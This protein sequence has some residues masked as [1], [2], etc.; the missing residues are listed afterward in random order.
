M[1]DPMPP[2]RSSSRATTIAFS[3]V[4]LGLLALLLYYVGVRQVIGLLVSLGWTAP[5]IMLPY[6]ILVI[7]DVIGWRRVLSG[8]AGRAL[9][10]WRLYVIRLAGEAVNSI[11]P[12]AGLAGEPVKAYLL[13]QHGIEASAGVA[14]VVIAKGALITAQI[15]FTLC[16]LALLLDLL[17]V[18][19]DQVLVLIGAWI[20]GIGVAVLIVAGQRVGVVAWSV[21]LLRRLRIRGSFVDRLEVRAREIDEVLIV[22]YRDDPR[23]FLIATAFHLLAWVLGAGEVIFFF[24]LMGVDCGLR[25]ALIIESLTQATMVSGAMIPGGL[26]V[27]ELGGAVLCRLVGIGEAAGLAMMLLKRIREIGFSLVGLAL[28]PYLTRPVP[29]DQ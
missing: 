11:T 19:R 13:R 14:S 10:L 2:A 6:G 3:A 28:L 1:T 8:P 18:L 25:E 17:D 23:G 15:L 29:A 22:F 20:V 5:L 24:L 9:S 4:G 7:F 12:T 27:Q 21:R 16:G 26:G